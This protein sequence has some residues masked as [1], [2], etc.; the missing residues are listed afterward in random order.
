MIPIPPQA[1]KLGAYA[2]I[3]GSAWLHGC[4]YGEQSIS[5]DYANFRINTEIVGKAAQK[6]AD[7]KAA[8]DKEKAHASDLSYAKAL[9]VLGS[10]IERMRKRAN[11]GANDLRTP[12]PTPLCAEGL[13]CFDRELFDSALRTFE[14]EV[15]T[16][17]GEGATLKLRMDEAVSW[18]TGK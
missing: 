11:S 5:A 14:G 2:L 4:R 3:L 10:H 7:I 18:A 9:S 13:R 17:V 8:K 15:L 12:A 1:L 16:L 6:E